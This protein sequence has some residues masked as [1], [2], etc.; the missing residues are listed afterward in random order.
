M[1]LVMTG[2]DWHKAPIDLR[3]SLSFTRSRV[4]ELDRRLWSREGVEGCVLLSTCNRTELYLSCEPG[5]EPDPGRLLCAAA[6]VPYAPFADA[7]VTRSGEK[8]ARHLMEVAGGLRSQIWGEDQIVTQVKAAAAAAREAGTADGVLETLFRNAAAAGK[9]IKTR[10]RFIGVPRSAARA[11]VDRLDQT[12][13]GLTGKRAMVIGNGEMGRLAASL[14]HQAGCSVTITLRSYHHGETVVPAG[15]SVT[16][17]EERYSAMG[18]MDLVLSATTSPH[19]TVTAWELAELTHPPKVLADLAIPR[20]IEPQVGTLP[21][22]TLY[23]VD[24]LGVDTSRE[25]P[26]EAVAIVEKYLDRLGQWENY[27]SCLP[28]LERVKQ[29]VAARV[30]ST[31]LEGPEARELVEL[32]VSRAVDLLSGGLKDNLTPEDLERCAAKIEVHTAAKPRWAMPPEKP[33]RFP[34]FI[35]LCGK[36]AV[37]IGGGAVA[38]RRAG[39]LARFGAE[40]TVIAPR[41]KPLEGGIQWQQRPYVPGDLAGAALAVAATDDRSV[42]RSVGEEARALG[43]PVSVADAPEECTFFFPAICTGDNIVA[44]VAGRGDDHARTARAAKA[45]RTVL[46]GLE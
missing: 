2:L 41:C 36:K 19:Y 25:I 12:L 40:V 23:N 37:V 28:S 26:Q 7:F 38:C 20:D 17:Y 32:A 14:L 22:F 13:G 33:F 24:D 10:V 46:E 27:R 8:A 15:C 3:E 6:G 43:I 21:G 42:N 29:A 11:A 31:D 44:G 45:I 1:N 30:L 35:D 34:I 5:A 4:L 18:G 9:E 16:P 39:V